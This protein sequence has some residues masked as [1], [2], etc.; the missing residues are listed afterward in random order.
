MIFYFLKNF[1]LFEISRKIKK[2]RK[3]IR[4]FRNSPLK[5]QPSNRDLRKLAQF[6]EKNILLKRV[7]RILLT[8]EP[9]KLPKPLDVEFFRKLQTKKSPSHSAK[10][11]KNFEGKKIEAMVWSPN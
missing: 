3:S 7:L 1:L 10:H 8:C 9:R 6:N 11:K 4:T 2:S 5:S